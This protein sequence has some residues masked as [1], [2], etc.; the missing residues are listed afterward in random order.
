MNIISQIIYSMIMD[1]VLNVVFNVIRKAHK[2]KMI[3]VLIAIVLY[4]LVLNVTFRLSEDLNDSDNIYREFD[5]SI[6]SP[7]K[8]IQK[9]F[10]KLSKIYHPDRHPENKEIYI[11]LV[12]LYDTLKNPQARFIYDRFGIVIGNTNSETIPHIFQGIMKTYS[13]ILMIIPF[14]L[15]NIFSPFKFK[16]VYGLMLILFALF[17]YM[18]FIKQGKDVLNMLFPGLLT[19]EI[20]TAL[21]NQMLY[22][23]VFFSRLISFASEKKLRLH[24]KMI[25]EVKIFYKNYKESLAE[26]SKEMEL[27]LS[28]KLVEKNKTNEKGD[29]VKK[30]GRE[31]IKQ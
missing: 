12:N 8:D 15:F 20:V 17:T 4:F 7:I 1:K 27:K 11:R 5:M 3:Q 13:K 18:I 19:H 25:E 6:Y 21:S 9:Q 30:N 28:K 10:K 16:V 31:E 14:L 24:K 22:Q 23:I 26:A 29:N 2:K